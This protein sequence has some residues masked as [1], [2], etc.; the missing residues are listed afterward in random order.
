MFLFWIENYNVSILHGFKSNN[1]PMCRS[2]AQIPDKDGSTLVRSFLQIIFRK[3][4]IFSRAFP[5]TPLNMNARA[6][7]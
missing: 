7:I 1:M 2:R 5:E 6:Q 4:V 3:I